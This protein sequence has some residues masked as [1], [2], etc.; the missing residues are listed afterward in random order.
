[1]LGAAELHFGRGN[2]SGLVYPTYTLE[3]PATKGI[4]LIG[5]GYAGLNYQS[6][7]VI[8]HDDELRPIDPIIHSD[9]LVSVVTYLK[10]V[11]YHLRSPKAHHSISYLIPTGRCTD[12]QSSVDTEDHL[13][14]FTH[15]DA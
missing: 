12:E 11:I 15:R 7:F 13:V 6:S 1:M 3:G 9:T 14:D 2:R 8:T 5:V 4:F 10:K